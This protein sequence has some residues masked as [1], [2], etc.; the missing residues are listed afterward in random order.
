MTRNIVS[1]QFL[2]VC[3]CLKNWLLV[4]CHAGMNY[5]LGEG[6]KLLLLASHSENKE[7]KFSFLNEGTH[8]RTVFYGFG[9]SLN[10]PAERIHGSVQSHA[11][12]TRSLLTRLWT[13]QHSSLDN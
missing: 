1:A 4:N 13:F 7:G 11:A 6:A 9:C 5:A 2:Q 12:H 10:T 8:L 3:L